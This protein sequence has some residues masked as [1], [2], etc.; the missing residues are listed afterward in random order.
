M[1]G[2]GVFVRRAPEN[3]MFPYGREVVHNTVLGAAELAYHVNS[4]PKSNR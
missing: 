1:I 3:S 2:Q 4:T